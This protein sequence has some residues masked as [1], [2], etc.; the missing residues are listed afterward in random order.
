MSVSFVC[1][2]ILIAWSS[3]LSYEAFPIQT[4]SVGGIAGYFKVLYD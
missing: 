2:L 1:W 4:S 3:D